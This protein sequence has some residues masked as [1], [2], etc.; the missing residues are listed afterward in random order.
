MLREAV[1]SVLAQTIENFE[2]IIVDDGSTD[3]TRAVAQSIDDDRVKY[4]ERVHAGV[5]A[6]RNS[7]VA[8]STAPLIAFLDS[9]DLW[10]PDKLE[11]QLEFFN[12]NP[13][14]AICQTEEVWMR[15]GRRVNPMRK[16]GKLSGWIFEECLP[17][18]IVSPSAVMMKKSIFES[19]G[20][21]DESLPACEDYDLWL[22]ASLRYPIHTLP[23]AQI[24]KRGGHADQL[25]AQWGLDRYRIKS[26]QGLLSDPL[27]DDAKR[28]RIE[29]EI[30]RRARIVAIGARKRGNAE[31]AD[32]Y[33][34]IVDAHHGHPAE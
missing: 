4:M 22:R 17:L 2:L 32:R 20:G 24:V 13:D 12:A 1:D 31:M 33:E 16:H 3:G 21:F 5:A 18:C 8:H 14:A 19:L 27:L 7:G 25:S 30:A 34:S 29:C 10:M 15:R 6:A 28:S 26:L 23:D 11:I 9:D